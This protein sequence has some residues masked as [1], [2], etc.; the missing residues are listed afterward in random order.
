MSLENIWFLLLNIRLNIFPLKIIFRIFYL[1]DLSVQVIIGIEDSIVYILVKKAGWELLLSNQY[2]TIYVLISPGSISCTSFGSSWN[3][4]TCRDPN[5]P[6]RNHF[7][8]NSR[9]YFHKKECLVYEIL[10]AII[11]SSKITIRKSIWYCNQ[12]VSLIN[13]EAERRSV[14]PPP[15]LPEICEHFINTAQKR[16]IGELNPHILD[17]QARFDVRVSID[18]VHGIEQ[19]MSNFIL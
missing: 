16:L 11:F 17:V 18:V 7:F 10:K 13:R 2:V 6:V 9:L 15:L 8:G 3:S 12:T 19:N 14:S 1:I 5:D 4:P